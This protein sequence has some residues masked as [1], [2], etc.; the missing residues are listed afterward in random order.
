MAIC[1]PRNSMSHEARILDA[2]SK[3]KVNCEEIAYIGMQ[4]VIE[5]ALLTEL[6]QTNPKAKL[7]L[8]KIFGITVKRTKLFVIATKI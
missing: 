7:R 1:V 6:N 2:I 8:K 4:K 5:D 3:A